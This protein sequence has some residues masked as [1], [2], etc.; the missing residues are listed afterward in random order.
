[1]Y[2]PSTHLFTLYKEMIKRELNNMEGFRIGGTI[3]NNL[4]YEDD[5]VI[6]PESEEQRLINVVVVKCEEKGLHLNSAK[7]LS[8]ISRQLLLY[9]TSTSIHVNILKQF[10]TFFY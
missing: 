8:I 6:L 4:R 1:M 2:V 3:V 7:S 5:T 9:E 10:Q